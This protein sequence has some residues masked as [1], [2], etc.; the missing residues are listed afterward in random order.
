[1]SSNLCACYS[2]R[3]TRL[4]RSLSTTLLGLLRH[5]EALEDDISELAIHERVVH[6]GQ[7]ARRLRLDDADIVDSARADS[8]HLAMHQRLH[9]F[10]CLADRLDP[11]VV[12]R[13]EG[14]R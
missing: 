6:V 13:L 5:E 7:D 4:T 1:M 12:S 10:G 2:S 9:Q 11:V 3:G 14:R 8:N